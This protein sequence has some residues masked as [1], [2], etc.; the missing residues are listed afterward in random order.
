MFLDRE[1][2]ICEFIFPPVISYTGYDQTCKE[3]TQRLEP[4]LR[5]VPDHLVTIESIDSTWGEEVDKEKGSKIIFTCKQSIPM[6]FYEE[7]DQFD[8]SYSSW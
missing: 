1:K 6:A 4:G 2:M 5:R 7:S 8:P 3:E